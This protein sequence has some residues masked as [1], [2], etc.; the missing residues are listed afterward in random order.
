M[1][2]L[3]GLA[4]MLLLT[5]CADPLDSL[6]RL[7]DVQLAETDPVAQAVPTEDE[8]NREGFFGTEA[9]TGSTG[10]VG[11]TGP[12]PAADE[13]GGGLLGLF[14]GAA[15]A[16]GLQEVDYGTV[17]PYGEVARSCAA[18]GRPLGRKIATAKARGYRLFDS[19]P[20]SSGLRTF[21]I[22]GFP[23]G[24]PRQ[25][26]AANVIFGAPSL[27]EQLR[28]GPTG[29]HLAIGET[30]AAYDRVKR[31]VCGAGKSKPCGSKIGR[32]D[33]ETFFV[34]SYPRLGATPRWSEILIHD[35]AVVASGFKTAG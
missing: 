33:R 19:A 7:S 22:T 23:D 5:A 18:R 17:L 29:A 30:D 2:L 9:A 13:R 3:T 12:E 14:G 28:Y 1:K 26:T 20:R 24:C 8:V 4:A 25:L 27:Y 11:R 31:S 10:R 34:T 16:N 21:Y 32:M 6:D 35:G 15:A